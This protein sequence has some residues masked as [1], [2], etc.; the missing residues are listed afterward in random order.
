M[1]GDLFLDFIFYLYTIV[2]LRLLN[3]VLFD[4]FLFLFLLLFYT[5]LFLLLL[6]G[7]VLGVLFHGVKRAMFA[8]RRLLVKVRFRQDNTI[9]ANMICDY[10]GLPLVVGF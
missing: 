5:I 7:G 10:R 2:T 6:N 4:L 8:A 3:N 9:Q 1:S